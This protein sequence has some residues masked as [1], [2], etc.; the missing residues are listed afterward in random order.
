[1]KN[2]SQIV[3]YRKQLTTQKIVLLQWLV[4]HS[5]PVTVQENEG[6]RFM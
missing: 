3:S 5:V 2:V 1:M 4:Q 6:T